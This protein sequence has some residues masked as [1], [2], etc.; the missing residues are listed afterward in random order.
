MPVSQ[1]A[2]LLRDDGEIALS[3]IRGSA[4]NFEQSCGML[5][6]WKLK[7]QRKGEVG[8]DLNGAKL[9]DIPGGS[10]TPPRYSNR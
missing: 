6:H 5:L 2:D 1:C 8:S 10:F 9:S 3:V 4:G 7:I